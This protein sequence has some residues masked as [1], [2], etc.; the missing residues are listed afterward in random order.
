[1]VMKRQYVFLFAVAIAVIAMLSLVSAAG[2]GEM[3]QR[4]LDGLYDAVKPLLQAIVGETSDSANFLAKVLLVILIIAVLYGA[5]SASNVEVFTDYPWVHWTT[6]IV[7]AILGVR[8][9][10]PELVETVLLPN[11]VFGVAVASGIPFVVYFILLRGFTSEFL[12]RTA[13]A[14]FAVVFLA[15]WNLR[16]E[17]L[18]DAAFIYPLIAVLALI[19]AVF[20]GKIQQYIFTSRINRASAASK[21]PALTALNHQLNAIHADYA[22]QTGGTAYTPHTAAS[23]G[24]TGYAAYRADVKDVKRRIRQLMRT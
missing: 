6:S 13:W 17:K 11:S 12:R 14:F 24:Q 10:T 20:E 21:G 18:G 19:M 4:G 3:V 1:M 5:L 16:Y 9:L 22:A 7:L 2:L 15:L 8:F 23:A